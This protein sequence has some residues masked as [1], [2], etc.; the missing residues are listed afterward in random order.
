MRAVLS[1]WFKDRFFVHYFQQR[2]ALPPRQEMK[3]GIC[4]HGHFNRTKGFGV[5]DYYPEA[6]QFIA[7]FR[8]PLEA[9]V[10]NYFFWK[11]KARAD[12]IRTGALR[13]GDAHDYSDINDFFRK[14]PKSNLLSFLPWALTSGNFRDALDAHFVWIGSTDF[15]QADVDVLARRLGFPPVA[16]GRINASPRDEILD[17]D[18][19][20]AFLR[21]NALE[22]EIY[23]YMMENRGRMRFRH[24]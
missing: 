15:L 4:I 24:G 10:S 20:R 18:L 11:I 5:M 17:P 16:V 9:A 23:R 21:E 2:Q 3:P 6:D 8:D 19:R 7:V 1:G 14:R 13:K 22:I 12:Q